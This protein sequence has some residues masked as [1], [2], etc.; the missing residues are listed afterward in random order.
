MRK[1]GFALVLLAAVFL[2]SPL[3]AQELPRVYA[4][5]NTGAACPQPWLPAFN[6]LPVVQTLPD[7]FAW[8]D[9]RGRLAHVSDWRCRRIEIGAALQRYQLGVKP[10]PPDSLEARLVGDTLKV[11]V[12]TGGQTLDLTA[13]IT[14]P[15][16]GSG[17]FPAVIGVGSGSGSLP[18]DLFTNRSVATIRYN[19]DQVAPWTQSGRGLGGFYRLYPDP[20]V[21]YLTAW[22]WGISRLIDG[23]E[24]VPQ[25]N[26][27]LQ[28]LAVTGCSFAGKIALYSGAL[29]ERIALTIA[30]EPGGGGDAAWRV[31]ETLSGSRETLRNAQSYGWYAADASLFNNAVTRLPIDQHEMMAMIAPRALLV[32]GNPD[33]EWLA[34]ESGYVACMAA[35]EVWKALGVPDRFGFSKAGGHL[36][37]S[38][39]ASQRPE[40]QAFIDKF[41]LGVE[42]VD[43]HVA[44]HPGYTTNLASWI[45]WSTPVLDNGA[46]WWGKASLIAPAHQ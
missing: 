31:T 42:S 24:K 26:I 4:A 38:L 3:S 18:A 11:T 25:A 20:Q 34:D 7:P 29:D 10:L 41:L 2:C 1:T 33:Y 5:E 14:L 30:Q 35:A 28:H 23:L 9:G 40:V 37:C 36:H 16:S 27:D 6:E 21:G 43:T 39:P 46:S 8:A 13:I 22:A 45:K 17:P 44:I 12:T 19:F 32:L 15:Q